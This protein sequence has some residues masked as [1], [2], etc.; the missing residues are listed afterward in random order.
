MAQSKMLMAMLL[1]H[2]THTLI[3]RNNVKD[4]RGHDHA[5]EQVLRRLSANDMYVRNLYGCMHKY[6]FDSGRYRRCPLARGVPPD[7]NPPGPLAV[8]EVRPVP[9]RITMKGTAS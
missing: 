3:L 8:G 7:A 9:S 1:L 6:E 4:E 2:H 5:V